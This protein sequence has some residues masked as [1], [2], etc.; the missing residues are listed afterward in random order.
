MKQNYKYLV[1]LPT[2]GYNM[3]R[4]LKRFLYN[5]DKQTLNKSLWE[6]IYVDDSSTDGSNEVL[7]DA[8][9]KYNFNLVHVKLPTRLKHDS[10]IV[11]KNQAYK[12]AQ[13]KT[14]IF[15]NVESL[16]DDTL[17]KIVSESH[18][19]KNLYNVG[20]EPCFTHK[21]V[22]TW[23]DR[24]SWETPILDLYNKYKT[25]MAGRVPGCGSFV[26]TFCA[27]VDTDAVKAIKGFDNA[28]K[29]GWGWA[30]DDIVKRLSL[31]GVNFVMNPKM[32]S[33]H[34][35]HGDL[36]VRDKRFNTI[37]YNEK[38]KNK[39]DEDIKIIPNMRSWGVLPGDAIITRYTYGTNK[40]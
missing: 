16:F 7:Q 5:C 35:W 38:I 12:L 4:Y 3:G 23:I 21:S 30:D 19:E 2:N 15:L 31:Y 40:N 26:G 6:V 20:Y 10:C 13:G 37:I 1:S 32:V 27:S 24:E 36:S 22:Q 17:F 25:V 29:Y 11:P 28:Y 8:M 34:Q 14:T 9:K 33:M 18:K 39:S